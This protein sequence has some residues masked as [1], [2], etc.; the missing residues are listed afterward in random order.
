MLAACAMAFACVKPETPEPKPEPEEPVEP[1]VEVA[2][3][4]AEMLSAE[5]T[6][7]TEAL[8]EYAYIFS[9][10]NDLT[11][12][13]LM[14]FKDGVVGELKDGENKVVISGLEAATTYTV[15]FA[16]KV[17][18]DEFYEDVVTA[19]VTT[20]DYQ[21]V[22][23]VVSKSNTGFKWHLKMPQSVKDAKHVLRYNVG[24]LPMYKMSKVGWMS[25]LEPDLLL[26]NGQH[27]VM[28]DT[29]LVYDDT[30]IYEL[31]ENGEQKIDEWTGEP[32]MLHT[33]FS[34]GEPIVFC[35]GEF[36][37]D[38]TDFTGWGEG[39]YTACYDYDAYNENAGGG[40][41]PWYEDIEGGLDEDAY[42]TGYFT[43]KYITLDPPAPLDA[44]VD[45]AFNV[46][47]MSGT[48]TFT[49]QADV[50]Q[51]CFMILPEYEYESLLPYIDNNED[52][53]QWF[54][55]SYT[56]AIYFGAAYSQE[57]LE[58]VLEDNYYLEPETT[59]HL[60]LTAMGDEKGLSQNFQHLTFETT[61]KTHPAPTVVVTPIANPDRKSVV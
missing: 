53:L 43:R 33:P 57:P 5:F 28:G 54:T 38:D 8:V 27:H 29:T 18:A 1:S 32:L 11:T 25:M 34:P 36:A 31:D 46:G 6:L 39:W 13:P 41:G 60:L 49:P 30:T 7:K 15:Y 47:A 2:V 3:S 51:Y 52:Y 17:S 12:E 45:V 58:L 19:Q 61:A 14:I 35:A 16:F 56:A 22:F 59:Y 37:W 21:D 42:W 9:Q 23:T 26:Q 44:K 48:V 50:Y 10:L 4:A 55:T 24:S 40:W 20:T